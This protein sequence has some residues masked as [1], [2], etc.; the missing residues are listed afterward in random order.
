MWG[1][2]REIATAI[3]AVIALA[4]TVSTP[5]IWLVRKYNKNLK[6][7]VKLIED[8][9]GINQKQWK[10]IEGNQVSL[11]K[12]GQRLEKFDECLEENVKQHR[13]IIEDIDGMTAH[14]DGLRKGLLVIIQIELDKLL[15]RCIH[16]GCRTLKDSERADSL[17]AAY[18]GLKGNHGMNR[19]KADFDKLLVK[20]E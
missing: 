7:V 10:A 19:K 3:S 14:F 5:F 8:Q 1:T 4:V 12:H 13:A 20:S 16:S 18:I 2:M 15:C 17:Y 11:E 9:G 6:S